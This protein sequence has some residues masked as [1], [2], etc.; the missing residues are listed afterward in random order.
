MAPLAQACRSL[1][2]APVLAL[3]ADSGCWSTRS[4]ERACAA[5]T[6]LLQARTGLAL[7]E[8][9]NQK[10]ASL[11]P[12]HPPAAPEDIKHE[13]GGMPTAGDD[14]DYDAPTDIG[15]EGPDIGKLHSE[16]YWYRPLVLELHNYYRCMH[17]APPLEWSI[18]IEREA[19]SWAARG[20]GSKSPPFYRTKVGGFVLVGENIANQIENATA[21][22]EAVIAWYEEMPPPL[23][24]VTERSYYTGEYTQMVWKSSTHVGCGLWRTSLVCWYGPTGN[25]DG[26]FETEVLPLSSSAHLCK[27]PDELRKNPEKLSG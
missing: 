18:G 2:I 9:R 20:R 26:S 12:G 5:D 3:G 23:G 4:G 14:M 8:G 6:V 7:R 16:D 25:V 27:I 10:A 1:L 11:G 13:M 22:R 24:V 15:D 17:G 21:A 19:K